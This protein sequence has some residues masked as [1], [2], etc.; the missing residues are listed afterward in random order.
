MKNRIC[1]SSLFNDEFFR[2][3][4]PIL[5]WKRPCSTK[6]STDAL[7]AQRLVLCACSFSGR[8]LKFDGA[9]NT[10]L[11]CMSTD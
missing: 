4:Q 1:P 2:V 9:P 6:I 8:K 11:S 5:Q 7:A 10:I 3:G